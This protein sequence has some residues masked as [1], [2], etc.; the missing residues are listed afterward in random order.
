MPDT[1]AVKRGDPAVMG[2][3]T[4]QKG[5][6]QAINEA[7]AQFPT[8]APVP[9]PPGPVDLSGQNLG[10]P[11]SPGDE[12]SDLLLGPTDRPQERIGAGPTMVSPRPAGLEGYIP[13]LQKAAED[14]TAPPELHRFLA[15]LSYH[16]GRT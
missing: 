12:T 16:L 10:P 1:P 14:P 2:D 13:I 4:L 3:Q 8:E 9:Q 6:A 15:L 11:P 7:A 5:D